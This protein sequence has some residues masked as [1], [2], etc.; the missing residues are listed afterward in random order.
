MKFSLSLAVLALAASQAMAVIP[1]PIKECTKT[2]VVQDVGHPLCVSITLGASGS[3]NSTSNVP[4]IVTPT[5]PVANQTSA[6][7]PAATH[8]SSAANPPATT[9]TGSV[10]VNKNSVAV[11]KNSAASTKSSMAMA[12][13]GILVSVAY[14]L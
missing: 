8:S 5:A 11:D 1:E 6:T 3:S 13:A 7:R 2:V 12:A 14:M 9:S 10:A 4:A